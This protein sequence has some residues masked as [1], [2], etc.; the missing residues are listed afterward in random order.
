MPRRFL[1]PLAVALVAVA[2]GDSTGS[3]GAPPGHVYVA[4]GGRKNVLVFETPLTSASVPVD[5]IAPDTSFHP[6][7]IAVSSG[8]D[9]A[10]CDNKT[11]LVF[12]PPITSASVPG[13]SVHVASGGGLAVTAGGQLIAVDNNNAKI[14]LFNSPLSASSTIADSIASG[15]ASPFA[16]AM[17]PDGKLYV[18]NGGSVLVFT[19]PFS[20]T[21]VPAVVVTTATAD[22]SGTSGIS[23]R[24]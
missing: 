14:Y 6:F 23:V 7:G 16:L 22:L 3:P 5:T 11:I 21:S 9:V 15:L 4:N 10:V 2:C 1:V 19:P 18:G 12:H 17:G 13:D 8:G 20:H 24:D